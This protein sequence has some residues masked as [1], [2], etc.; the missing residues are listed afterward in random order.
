M[1][2]KKAEYT[3]EYLNTM[4]KEKKDKTFSFFS[5]QSSHTSVYLMS[6]I[7]VSVI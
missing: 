5:L 4:K 1:Q 2:A 7:F 6:D 3:V